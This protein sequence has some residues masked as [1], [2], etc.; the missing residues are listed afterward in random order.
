MCKGASST[1]QGDQAGRGSD[2]T[3]SLVAFRERFC[4]CLGRRTDAL[5]ELSDAIL[6]AGSVPSAV[7]LSL[8][9]VH[10]RGWGSLYAALWRGTIDGEALR[11]LLARCYSTVNSA[12]PPVYAMDVSVWPRCDAESSPA[13]GYYYHPSR[14]SAGQ[15]IVSGWAHQLVAKLGFERD[16]WVAPFDVRRVSPVENASGVAT[17]QVKALVRRLPESDPAPLFVFDA[18]YDPVRLQRGGRSPG[19]PKGRLSGPAKRYPA[20]KKA[21]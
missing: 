10:R 7:H 12:E 14:H 16:S 9:A 1:K 5:F 3:T 13:R 11:G 6:S 4:A 17:E 21:A 18:G 15:P 20:V 19:R 2:A 8:P